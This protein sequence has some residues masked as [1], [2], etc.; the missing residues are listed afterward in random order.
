MTLVPTRPE[1]AGA[2][3]SLPARR[4][5][6]RHLAAAVV[7]WILLAVSGLPSLA[8]QETAP[9][10]TTHNKESAVGSEW[11]STPAKSRS[12]LD[13]LPPDLIFLP[14]RN[15]QL[16]PVPR[17][18]TLEKWLESLRQPRIKPT[19]IPA[20]SIA[21]IELT[22]TA[23]D[24]R[25]ILVARFVIQNERSD[26]FVTLPLALHEAVLRHYD[27]E[28][29]GDFEFQ[30][31]DRTLGS[32]WWLRG[33]GEHI[34]TMEISVP[35]KRQGTGRRLQLSLP[36]AAMSRLNLATMFRGVTAKSVSGEI[37]VI[38]P[39]DQVS[40][41]EGLGLGTKLDLTWQPIVAESPA[42][43]LLEADTTI[44]AHASPETLLVEAYQR[45]AVLQGSISEV[46]V[47]LPPGAELLSI[48]GRDYRAHRI[49][50]DAPTRVLVQLAPP[51][52]GQIP[53]P[54]I[55]LKWTIRL[56]A[57]ENRRF[58]LEGFQVEQARKQS[59]QIGLIPVEG[60]RMAVSN[61]DHP[62]LLRINAAELK[63]LSA[64]VSRAYRFFSQPFRMV[65]T[66]ETI[67]PYFTVEPRF[68]LHARLDEVTLEGVFAVKI[69]RGDL[70]FIELDWPN[71]KADGWILESVEPQGE[72][73]EGGDPERESQP[74]RLRLPLVSD[75]GDQ[76]VLRLKAK[77]PMRAGEP[78]PVSLPRIVS[79]EY[80]PSTLRLVEADNL[81]CE[82]TPI[83]ETVLDLQT[84][85]GVS[86][87]PEG[88]LEELGR[89]RSYR[90]AAGEQLFTL[91]AV[92]QERRVQVSSVTSLELA[93]NRIRGMQ[94][95]QFDVAH[96]R[97][98]KVRIAVP[99]AW[100]DSPLR[101]QLD[102]DRPL[103]VTWQGEDTENF[104]VALVA[105]PEPRL[106]P[107]SLQALFE[108]P[109][110]DAVLTGESDAEVP[111]FT[112]VDHVFE[113][114][115][116][117]VAQDDAP[118][119]AV[120][121]ATWNPRT[122][123]SGRTTWVAAGPAASVRIQLDSGG[124]SQ[125]ALIT[126]AEISGEWDRQGTARCVARYR[127]S[128]WFARIGI[129]LPADATLVQAAWDERV[130]SERGDIVGDTRPRHYTL[131]V[132]SAG[133]E[134]EEHWLTLHYRLTSKQACGLWNQWTFPT[135]QLPQARWMAEGRWQIRFPSDQHLFAYG[136]AVTP[137]FRW[138]RQGAIW[139]RISPSF[140]MAETTPVGAGVV[141]TPGTSPG[142]VYVFRQFG[143]SQGFRFATMSGP[144]ILFVGASV[145]LM[146][147][148]LLLR[149]T[150]LR[151]LLT[152]WFAVF[153]LAWAGLWFRPQLEVLLQ[154]ILVG[155]LFPVLAVWLQGL[156]RRDD[157]AVLSFDPLLELSEPR[158][159]INTGRYSGE[160]LGQEPVLVRSPS[161]ST[162]DFLRTG[163][164]SGVP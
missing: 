2:V 20:P 108:L 87:Q 9:A 68:T 129:V 122:E 159:S 58:T 136:A 13:L 16:V 74:G 163:L 57:V 154:P 32:V 144:M 55:Q 33:A 94:Q 37:Q 38:N 42:A 103:P 96:E 21:S 162:H 40:R 49:S 72:V 152:A 41:I 125:T 61:A 158:S 66:A 36:D 112:C 82:L 84:A 95:F 133:T 64:Q 6:D 56:P 14:D 29:P 80:V 73:L 130:L 146:A 115:E 161:G 59:G 92:K 34:V 104:A 75:H 99:R 31:N 111:I 132:R 3:T 100:R 63:P 1:S 44:M 109:L 138:Q 81:S 26:G 23:D 117:Q 5:I 107:F 98:G 15:N 137:E 139:K 145:S 97:L 148:F 70:R 17:E 91:R 76:F 123:M 12:I 114:I 134:R 90:I 160:S 126:A 18:A 28:G 71:W 24:E 62:H 45:L 65:L 53:P 102:G 8:A 106:G 4:G 77:R 113:R 19:E 140:A 93:G 143:E 131:R 67:E 25:A 11:K 141:T 54:P 135:P 51:S 85:D 35:V 27:H 46:A 52:T 116:L 43:P 150:R 39:P 124:G 78:G 83:G 10:D 149:V 155:M 153:A 7:A 89:S 118:L 120:A 156:R 157:A 105:F 86:R 30:A 60:L 151:S 119:I 69:L 47:H 110:T 48:E 79:S 142:N 128:G 164:G 127:L 22:G 121:D 88:N 101:F 50:A 147:G